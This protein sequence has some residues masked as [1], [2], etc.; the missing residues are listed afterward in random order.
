MMK[1][2]MVCL[3]LKN[4][5]SAVRFCLWPRVIK[6]NSK[7]FLF[8]QT[9]LV[10]FITFFINRGVSTKSIS[11]GM[12]YQDLANNF[13]DLTNNPIP[14]RILLPF[15]SWLTRVP[16]Q[17]LNLLFIVLF[18]F[19]LLKELNKNFSAITAVL[20]VLSISTTMVVQFTLIYGGYPDIFIFLLILLTMIYKESNY[21]FFILCIGLLLT[22]EGI[23]FIIPYLFLIRDKKNLND[24]IKLT[25]SLLLFFLIYLFLEPGGSENGGIGW[26]FF[27]E[28]FLFDLK[29]W[30]TQNKDYFFLGFFSSIK[31][32]WL[33]FIYQIV[34]LKKQRFSLLCLLFMISLQFIFVSGDTTRYWYLIVIGIIF[35]FNYLKTKKVLSILLFLIVIFNVITPKY[36][37]FNDGNGVMYTTPND[38]RLHFF[39]VYDLVN[40]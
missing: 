13:P 36:Y 7:F 33:L 34:E 2:Q 26:K 12:L 37:V 27:L 25:T 5:G 10:V 8:S 18:I 28:P 39:D 30:A 32:L 3:Y 11:L 24:Y 6:S 23:I 20:F 16:I 15:L 35:S 29:F 17:Y 22:R 31:F 4:K 9:F 38:S 1:G 21:I 40:N 19:L 14:H